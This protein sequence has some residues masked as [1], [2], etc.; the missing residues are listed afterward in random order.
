M[1]PYPIRYPAGLGFGAGAGYVD[2]KCRP[3]PGQTQYWSGVQAAPAA[4]SFISIC[5]A[6]RWHRTFSNISLM[7][8][9]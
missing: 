4:G 9:F 3:Q 8:G 2:Q 5:V 1:G 6:Q 7:A